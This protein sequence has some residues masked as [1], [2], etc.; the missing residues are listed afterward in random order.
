[1]RTASRRS[2]PVR[3]RMGRIG[4]AMKREAYLVKRISS[5]GSGRSLCLH[6]SSVFPLNVLGASVVG[7]EI[8]NEPPRHRAHRVDPPEADVFDPVNLY[9]SSVFFLGVLCASVVDSS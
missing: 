8:K 4:E 7:S 6:L 3:G 9:L 5:E 2:C 1:M